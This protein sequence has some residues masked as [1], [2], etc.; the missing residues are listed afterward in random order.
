MKTCSVTLKVETRPHFTFDDVNVAPDVLCLTHTASVP[1]SHGAG[2]LMDNALRK[3]ASDEIRS[4]LAIAKI[5]SIPL[6]GAHR[7]AGT[8]I[9]EAS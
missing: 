7:A 1:T 3:I 9:T 5:D 8:A 4:D 6:A 2:I